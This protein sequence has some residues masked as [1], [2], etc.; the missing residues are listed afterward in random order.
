VHLGASFIASP[1]DLAEM[2]QFA[3]DKGIK[4]WIQKYPMDKVNQAV[5]DMHAGKARYRYVLVNEHNGAKL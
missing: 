5:V 3:G 1:S 2:L 4:P